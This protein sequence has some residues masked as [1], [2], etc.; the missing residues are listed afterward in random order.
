MGGVTFWS[1]G[2]FMILEMYW[3]WHVIWE[4]KVIRFINPICI[5]LELLSLV[6][7]WCVSKPQ[8][9]EIS[10]SVKCPFLFDESGN[11]TESKVTEP[12]VF[13]PAVGRC[14]S[15]S[16]VFQPFPP[17]LPSFH[18]STLYSNKFFRIDVK[19]SLV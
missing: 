16:S 19:L 12:N 7:V 2:H 14:R 13:M 10:E 6:N 11:E 8:G 15:T 18:F 1:E 9:S 3:N 5:L 4:I 17:K